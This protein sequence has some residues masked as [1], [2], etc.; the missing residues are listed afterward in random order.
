MAT[1]QKIPGNASVRISEY[2]FLLSVDTLPVK[3]LYFLF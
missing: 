2:E 1:M 3:K